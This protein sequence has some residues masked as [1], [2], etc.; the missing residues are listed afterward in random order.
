MATET[1]MS[2]SPRTG[3]SRGGAR[4]RVPMPASRPEFLP[5]LAAWFFDERDRLLGTAR[6]DGENIAGEFALDG[7][8]L[9]RAVIGPRG[10]G[11]EEALADRSLPCT[12]RESC[13]A[14]QLEFPSGW[15]ECF[16]PGAQSV[17]RGRAFRPVANARLP[18]ACGC[19]EAYAV[20]PCG[21]IP[22]RNDGE[23]LWLRDRLL[24]GFADRIPSPGLLASCAP[25]QAREYFRI[26][27]EA[28]TPCLAFLLPDGWYGM[29]RIGSFRIQADGSFGG[30]IGW[31]GS[32]GRRPHLYFTVTQERAGAPVVLHAPP[33]GP[34]TAWN[35]N[36]GETLLCIDHPR[37]ICRELPCAP[38]GTVIAFTGIGGDPICAPGCGGGLAQD[39]PYLGCFR[40][41]GGAISPY[42]GGLQVTLEADL[43]ALHECGVRWYRFSWC[44]GNWNGASSAPVNWQPITQPISR[45]YSGRGARAAGRKGAAEAATATLQTCS[46]LPECDGLPEPLAGLEGVFRLPDPGAEW[47]IARPEE[48]AWAIWNT[49][50]AHG[51]CTIRMQLFDADGADVTDRIPFRHLRRRADGAGASDAAPHGP[52]LHVFVDNRPH[53]AARDGFHTQHRNDPMN[54]TFGITEPYGTNVP[55]GF[56]G[57]N[58]GWAPCPPY[59]MTTPF[60]PAT[61]YGI[62]WNGPYGMM[63]PYY[64]GMPGFPGMMTGMMN[65]Y[66]T[67]SPGYFGYGGYHSITGIHGGPNPRNTYAN[68][69]AGNGMCATPVG[70]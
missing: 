60:P 41:P 65:P 22:Q 54:W 2:K 26:H 23:I 49:A 27:G 17:V 61:P 69:S 59:A 9:V 62:G 14:D 70:C 45:S 24:A 36:G 31:S 50:E 64:C 1:L 40:H 42:S 47:L 56:G 30:P 37:A 4:L 55:F 13:E 67:A 34:G 66:W 32:P 51:L 18:L 38:A 53:S 46:L 68:V 57:Y 3:G 29:Q 19:V 44:S 28:L 20:D 21:W 33:I 11:A 5:E 39:E 16:R 52:C 58:Y 15:W 12:V 10:L 63:N 7:V 43:N 6:V 25:Q 48:R 35:W 8:R